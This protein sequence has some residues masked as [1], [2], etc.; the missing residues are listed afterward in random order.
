M[1]SQHVYQPKQTAR[2]FLSRVMDEY[3]WGGGINMR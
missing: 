1:T 3:K 2:T